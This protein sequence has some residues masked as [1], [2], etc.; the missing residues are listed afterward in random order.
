MP[1]I[2]DTFPYPWSAPEA[3]QLHLTLSQ[4]HPSVQ[5]A[6]LIAQ[7]TGINTLMIDAQQPVFLV[8]AQIL[9]AAAR[10]DLTRVL[11]QGVRDLLNQNNPRRSFLEDLL[12]NKPLPTEGE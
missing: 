3:Q 11:V 5:G 7:R 6:L 2:L 4:L 10:D 8:W 12:A 1:S 9:D